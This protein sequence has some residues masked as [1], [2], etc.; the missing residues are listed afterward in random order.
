MRCPQVASGKIHHVRR[1]NMKRILSTILALCMVL[2]LIVAVP[3]TTSAES[4]G[5][6]GVNSSTVGASGQVG[7]DANK[8]VKKDLTNIPDITTVSSLGWADNTSVREY[9]ITNA[10]G[11]K[12][13]DNLQGGS[14]SVNNGLAGYTFY[15]A[16]DIDLNGVTDFY[17]IGQGVG[18]QD[19][20]AGTFDGQ[21]YAI[22][23]WKLTVDANNAK[24]ENYYGTGL[25]G[26]VVS[27][28]VIKNVVMENCAITMAAGGGASGNVRYIGGL[29]GWLNRFDDISTGSLPTVENCKVS[30]NLTSEHASS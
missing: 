6:S 12:K 20:F 8:V 25:F 24:N 18:W 16:N 2:S 15:L 26:Y 28:A 29:V 4:F 1:E 13:L 7:Y 17:G 22:K 21:G 27:C 14:Q 3:F 23:N 30:L 11:L 10:A 19:V 5:A 9:K